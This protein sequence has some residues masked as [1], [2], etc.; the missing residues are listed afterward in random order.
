MSWCMIQAVLES[1]LRRVFGGLFVRLDMKMFL[2]WTVDCSNGV[3]RAALLKAGLLHNTHSKLP[4]IVTLNVGGHIF[5]TR[6]ATLLSD[7]NS[8]LSSMF[9]G[10]FDLEVDDEGRYFI[11]R[12]GK[13]FGHILNYL[14]DASIIPPS[15]VALQVYQEA[16]YYRTER[17]M[18]QLEC[19]P[20]VMVVTKINDQKSK[21]GDNF[22]HWKQ[23]LLNAVCQKYDETGNHLSYYIG[24]ELPKMDLVIP[25]NEINDICLFTSLL[26]KDLRSDGYCSK[27]LSSNSTT[28]EKET[29]YCIEESYFREI[30][31]KLGY[32]MV[33]SEVCAVSMETAR[34]EVKE[35][36]AYQRNGDCVITDA[37]HDSSRS[38]GHTTVCVISHT[39]KNVIGFSNWSRTSHVPVVSREVPMTKE[40]ITTLQTEHH[41]NIGEVAH[42][43]VVSLKKWF[44]EQHIVNSFD[45]WHGAKEIS[46]A[47]KNICGGLLRDMNI[48]WFPELSDKG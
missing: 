38:A 4:S 21:M 33:V 24:C 30:I 22:E 10:R 12:D 31:Q 47:M 17:L 18:A 46:K 19:Y 29:Y 45:S 13:Y 44:E 25:E 23:M 16:K 36:E 15:P 3:L 6:L 27:D 40:V 11:D 28:R 8:M 26:E 5:T 42:D 37:R 43:F 1:S 48:K 41:Y 9:S 35:T 2:C 20:S 32:A 14:R 39:N 34:S 7:E